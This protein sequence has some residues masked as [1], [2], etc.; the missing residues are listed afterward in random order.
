MNQISDESF[1]SEIILKISHLSKKYCRDLR[2]TMK[3]GLFDIINALFIRKKEKIDLRDG[4]F[5]IFRDLNVEVKKGEILGI[6]G[7]NGAGKSSLLK[8]ISNIIP[9]DEGEIKYYGQIGS[10]IEIGG[11]FIPSAT[12]RENIYIQA[13]LIGLDREKVDEIIDDII[14]FAEIGDFIDTPVKYYSSGMYVRLGFSVAVHC[15]PSIMLLDEVL[16]VGDL[17]FQEKCFDKFE[18]L[19]RK[20]MTILLV[21]HN[22]HMI[23]NFAERVLFINDGKWKI[24][25]DVELAINNYNNLFHKRNISEIQII[26]EKTG[27]ILFQN[28]RLTNPLINYGNN[29]EII[30]D[31]SNK[32]VE[33][34]IIIDCIIFSGEETVLFQATNRHNNCNL[35]IKTGEGSLKI[36]IQKFPF[37]NINGIIG[38]AIWDINMTSL[39]FW[40]RIPINVPKKDLI[41]GICPIS[42]SYEIYD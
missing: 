10:M 22:M 29:V 25:D 16:A 37:H 1:D 32:F 5:W 19:R 6:I 15:E 42:I 39:L 8:I 28:I 12:G 41:N 31:Y 33:K 20:G 9:P 30:L 24:F 7:P 35:L 34:E 27:E 11:G 26:K 13:S 23:S 4:E 17:G 2:K 36:L 40:A 18:E 14:A 38:I 21:S 3:Y